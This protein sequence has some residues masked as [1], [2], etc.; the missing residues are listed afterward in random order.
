MD[1]DF[2]QGIITFHGGCADFKYVKCR[3]WCGWKSAFYP[4]V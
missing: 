2:E 1:S 4:H 3:C